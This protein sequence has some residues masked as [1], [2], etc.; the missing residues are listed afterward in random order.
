MSTLL[1]KKSSLINPEK[2]EILDSRMLTNETKKLT[3]E[4]NI[5]CSQVVLK[6]GA[7]L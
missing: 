2:F 7:N 1:K 3:S 6:E 4:L 5:E